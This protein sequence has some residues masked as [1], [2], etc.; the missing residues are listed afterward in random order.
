VT[1]GTEQVGLKKAWA[2]KGGGREQV[3][4]RRV[5]ALLVKHVRAAVATIEHV[6]TNTTSRSSGSARHRAKL[7]ATTPPVK[8]K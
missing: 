7:L 3:D 6:V 5:I 2:G 8:K 1:P 4:K